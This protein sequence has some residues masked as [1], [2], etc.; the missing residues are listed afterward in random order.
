MVSET[1]QRVQNVRRFLTL[2]AEDDAFRQDLQQNPRVALDYLKVLGN[3]TPTAAYSVP[4]TLPSKDDVRRVLQ[5]YDFALEHATSI[6]EFSAWDG[7]SAWAAWVFV[8]L[9]DTGEDKKL[10]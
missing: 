3:N 7:W 4:I 6:V 1:M 8:F 2:L 10:N 9:A 5:S